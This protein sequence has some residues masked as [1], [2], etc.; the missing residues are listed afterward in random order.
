MSATLQPEPMTGLSHSLP[1]RRLL[2]GFGAGS[3][4][5]IVG[6]QGLAGGG[7][8]KQAGVTWATAESLAAL[9]TQSHL[10]V[11]GPVARR[12]AIINGARDGRAP[13]KPHRERF[14][15]TRIYHLA[16]ERLFKG[17]MEGAVDVGQSEDPSRGFVP[18]Q[19]GPHYLFF[20]RRVQIA[21]IAYAGTL[22]PWRFSISPAG[23]AKPESPWP[24]ATSRFPPRPV[25]DL[26]AEVER[27]LNQ[28]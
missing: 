20:L 12:G 26:V 28:R 22:E 2:L 4:V 10:I 25:A 9:V 21:E 18:L 23:E 14:T 1:R 5:S 7:R 19:V 3:L 24:G 11:L 6:C 8:V 15:P 13:T 17:S 27:L 16:P